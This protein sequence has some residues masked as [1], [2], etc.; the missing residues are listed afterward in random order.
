DIVVVESRIGTGSAA[1]P[2]GGVFWLRDDGT[3]APDAPVFGTRSIDACTL[4]AA[5][6]T[7]PTTVV[8]GDLNNDG[9]VDVVAGWPFTMAACTRFDNSTRAATSPQV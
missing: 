4:G 7:V 8:A 6:T 1:S 2:S 5:S 3:V 9:I